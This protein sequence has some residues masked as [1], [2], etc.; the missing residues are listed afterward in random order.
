MRALSVEEKFLDYYSK[1]LD[2]SHKYVQ[3]VI[4]HSW[5]SVPVV[6]PEICM[7]VF[8]LSRNASLAAV[9]YGVAYAFG[10]AAVFV[11]FAIIFRFGAYQ[12]VQPYNGPFYVGLD[13]IYTVFMLLIF[14][15]FA[16]GQSSDFAPNYAKAKNAAERIF[17]LLDRRSQLDSRGPKKDHQKPEVE[18]DANVRKDSVRLFAQQSNTESVLVDGEIIIL[19]IYTEIWLVINVY[20]F[21]VSG[22]KLTKMRLYCAKINQITV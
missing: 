6:V 4:G 1:R 19:D 2:K 14:G 13:R 9:G 7:V 20:K 16:L 15:T 5:F 22:K 18:E 11:S 10:Q 12:S 8:P 3:L 21:F 17:T